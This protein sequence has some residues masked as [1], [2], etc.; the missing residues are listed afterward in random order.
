MRNLF[1]SRWF[2]YAPD[3]GSQIRILKLLKLL[4]V[5]HY[6]DLISFA[7]DPV[8]DAQLKALGHYCHDVEVVRYR[9][10]HPGRLTALK[11]LHGCL[12]GF[13]TIKSSSAIYRLLPG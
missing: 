6:V 7:S 8:T 10:F 12:N 2:P 13:E 9:P 11:E 4:S 1:L 5:H 3:N